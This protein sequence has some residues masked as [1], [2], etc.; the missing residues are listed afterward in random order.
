MKNDTLLHTQSDSSHRPEMGPLTQTIPPT[1][2]HAAREWVCDTLGALQ[3]APVDLP[4]LRSSHFCVQTRDSKHML[5]VLR[6]PEAL[7]T[8][9]REKAVLQRLSASNFPA[10]TCGRS[11]ELA[12]DLACLVLDWVDGVPFQLETM[13]VERAEEYMLQLGG[14]LR[15]LHRSLASMDEFSF[16]SLLSSREYD[17]EAVTDTVRGLLG[18]AEANTFN[19]W[20]TLARQMLDEWVAVPVHGTLRSNSLFLKQDGTLMLWNFDSPGKDLVLRELHVDRIFST[21]ALDKTVRDRCQSKLVE[22]YGS[23][24]ISKLRSPTWSLLRCDEYAVELAGLNRNHSDDTDP[25]L[26]SH[27]QRRFSAMH[28]EL[29]ERRARVSNAERENALIPQWYFGTAQCLTEHPGFTPLLSATRKLFGSMEVRV[30]SQASGIQPGACFGIP[31]WQS[32]AWAKDGALLYVQSKESLLEYRDR[33]GVVTK[34]VPGSIIHVDP[35]ASLRFLPVTEVQN[36]C[37]ALV[38]PR[39][40][41]RLRL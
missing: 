6:G 28:E 32:C 19:G 2:P 15:T 17:L 35:E 31:E 11:V 24:R 39:K 26:K 23:E 13:G 20:L 36:A 8:M 37:L 27:W 18:D 21:E 34:P 5:K 1:L 3:F 14:L 33:D 22:G 12:P 4:G 41:K 25:A 10:P 38:Q 40:H 30:D 9:R 7:E 29:G 16:P